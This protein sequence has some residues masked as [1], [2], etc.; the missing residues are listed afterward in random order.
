MKSLRLLAQTGGLW[1]V[2]AALA[3]AHPGH[4]GDGGH[5]LT[6]DFSPRHL[7]AYPLATFGCAVALGLITWA[8]VRSAR[9]AGVGKTRR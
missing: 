9:N 2:S 7:A 4:E 6:W 3:Q 1:L 8:V 5:D